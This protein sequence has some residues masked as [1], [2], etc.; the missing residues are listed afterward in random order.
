MVEILIKSVSVCVFPEHKGS[1]LLVGANRRPRR[2]T[3]NWA[4][5]VRYLRCY[6]VC[7]AGEHR[8]DPTEPATSTKLQSLL[9]DNSNRQYDQ[10]DN[11][12]FFGVK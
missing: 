6:R 4:I 12:R 11:I 3:S 10:K 9:N 2:F 1:F 5:H 7:V 8:I